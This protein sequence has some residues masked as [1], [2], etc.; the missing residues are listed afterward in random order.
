MAKQADYYV[1]KV[2]YNN[3]DED[4]IEAVKRHTV[5]DDGS[6]KDGDFNTTPRSTVVSDI[7]NIL[8]YL[9]LNEKQDG[10]GWIFGEDIH[11]VNVDGEDFVRTDQNKTKQD[12][13]GELPEF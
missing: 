2:H 10:N 6:F 12:N 8:T 11:V 4:H 9:T 1:T 7:N 5:N 3:T 13:L